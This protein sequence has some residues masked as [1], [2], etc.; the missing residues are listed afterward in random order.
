M[1]VAFWYLTTLIGA[2]KVIDGT[3]TSWLYFMPKSIKE[4]CKELVPLIVDIAYL[5]FV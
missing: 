1:G 4:I 5:D 3:I 2:I